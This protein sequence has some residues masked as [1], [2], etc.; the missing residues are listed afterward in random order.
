MVEFLTLEGVVV[1]RR[2]K[3]LLGPV[4]LSLGNA[5]LTVVIGPNGSGKTT[6]LRAM[7]GLERLSD[8]KIHCSVTADEQAY[9]F[10]SPIMLRRSVRE[11]MIFPPALQR[12]KLSP[13]QL[14]AEVDKW[15]EIIG[16]PGEGDRPAPRLSGGE[17]QKL[18]LARALICK[19]KLLFLDEPCSNLDGRSTREI[20]TILL[21]ARDTGTRIIL[22][23]HDMG[24]VKRLAS[25]VVFVLNGQIHETSET[26]NFMNAPQTKESKA[27]LEG[28]IVE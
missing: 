6:L 14:G 19:P 26:G 15:L 7:H 24:Q 22:A 12:L 2:G 21:Q 3:R 11:N 23:T 8:G 27:F 4:D 28:D 16:L 9:V 18:A 25:D 1:R 10:Q 20:E 17:K 5:G 13:S